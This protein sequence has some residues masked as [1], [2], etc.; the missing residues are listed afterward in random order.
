MQETKPLDT[1]KAQDAEMDKWLLEGQ[2]DDPLVVPAP[3]QRFVIAA[4]DW[5]RANNTRWQTAQ[6]LQTAVSINDEEMKQQARLVA[7]KVRAVMTDTAKACR[8]A[9]DALSAQEKLALL[10]EIPPDAVR[11]LALAVPVLLG[12]PS[13]SGKG[14]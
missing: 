14:A 7:R 10:K 2:Q 3:M 4:S 11:G 13:K 9:W 6:Q 8:D 5:T 12:K 1:K